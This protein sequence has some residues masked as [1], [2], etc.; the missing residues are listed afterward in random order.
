[1]RDLILEHMLTSDQIFHCDETGLNFRML[2][3]QRE[4]TVPGHKKRTER[5]PI[6]MC[7]V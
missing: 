2:A 4:K 7:N 5:V 1:M 3:A 6:L